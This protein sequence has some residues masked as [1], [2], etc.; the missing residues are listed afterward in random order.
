M[1]VLVSLTLRRPL[2]GAR[3]RGSG[4]KGVLDELK[5]PELETITCVTTI[6]HAGLGLTQLLFPRCPQAIYD[7]PALAQKTVPF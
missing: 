3:A 5:G 4:K 7:G 6:S 2:F 1:Q